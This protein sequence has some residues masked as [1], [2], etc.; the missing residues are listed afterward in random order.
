MKSLYIF[1]IDGTIAD[2]SHR[3]HFI[4]TTPANW[5][6]FHDCVYNDMPISPVI[7][8]LNHLESMNDIWF[9]T[10]RMERTRIPTIKWIKKYVTDEEIILV[11]R[12]DGDYR[13]DVRV[14]QEM[15]DN[16]LDIDR[17][18]LVAV[19]DDRSRIVSMWRS[20]NIQCYQV[21]DGDY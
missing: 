7:S 6:A 21:K 15:L 16:M 17:H 1:D 18:R 2:L 8:T 10:G 20:N 5:D 19:F 12:P 3:L 4:Q 13:S 9:F 14:K 11:M